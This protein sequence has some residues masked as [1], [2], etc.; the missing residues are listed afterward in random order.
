MA[1]QLDDLKAR[2][3]EFHDRRYGKDDGDRKETVFYRALVDLESAFV[4]SIARHAAD[5]Q[6]LDYGCGIGERAIEVAA[7]MSPASLRGVDISPTAIEIATNRAKDAH[8]TVQYAVEDCHATGFADAEFDLVYG[9]GILHH[10][11]MDIALREIR[12][13]L[14][15]D[16]VAVFYEPMG[17]NP[18]I[19]LYR[20]LTPGAR[21]VDEHP[22]VASDLHLL[23]SYFSRVD[24]QY[25]GFFTL[26]LLPLYRTPQDSVFKL[27]SW[28]DRKLLQLPFIRRF[29]WSVLFVART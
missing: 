10:L 18:L 16:G 8:V 4:N 23:R 6:V 28:L 13:L 25:F 1:A 17:T 27:G 9:N 7:S 21:S 3:R 12:R 5:K 14:K 11:D 22:L 20:W 15:S 24:L 26:V 19:N 29:A 2:E